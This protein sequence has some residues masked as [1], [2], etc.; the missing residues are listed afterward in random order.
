MRPKGAK[1][2]GHQPP[3]HKWAHLSQVW[4]QND[5]N[6]LITQIGHKSV[7]GLWKPPEATSSAQNKDSPSS[8]HP[9]VKD[10]G[11]VH[12]WYNIPLCTIFAQQSNGDI[13]RNKLSDPKSSPQ[14]IILFEGGLF[15]YSVL[16]FPGGYQKTI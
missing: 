11:V 9:I 3:N 13:F 8:M 6:H 15:N 4:P 16:Q 2:A 10:P 14:S 12:I 1:V 5:Q 7:H